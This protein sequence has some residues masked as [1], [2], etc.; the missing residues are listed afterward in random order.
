MTLE[1]TNK[2]ELVKYGGAI[3]LMRIPPSY[4]EEPAGPHCR[5]AHA[6]YM[7]ANESEVTCGRCLRAMDSWRSPRITVTYR[8]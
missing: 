4:M 1:V 2:P 6:N 3:H 7:T 8:L 5:A